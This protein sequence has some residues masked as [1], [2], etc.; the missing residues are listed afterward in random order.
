[1]VVS[2]VDMLVFVDDVGGG[3]ADGVG[4]FM[5]FGDGVGVRSIGEFGECLREVSWMIRTRSR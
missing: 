2:K 3:A 1:M 5:F 4:K